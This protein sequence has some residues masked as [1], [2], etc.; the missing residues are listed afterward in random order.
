MSSKWSGNAAS[1][2]LFDQRLFVSAG[3]VQTTPETK[4]VSKAVRVSQTE[5]SHVIVSGS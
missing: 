3:T 2:S 4:T 1:L 5:M